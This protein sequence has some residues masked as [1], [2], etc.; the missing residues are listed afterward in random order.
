[1]LCKLCNGTRLIPFV[2][3]GKLIANAW[4]DCDCK[5]PERDH[6]RAVTA[7]GFDFPMSDT[8]RGYSFEYCGQRDPAQQSPK[9]REVVKEVTPQRVIVK[10]HYINADSPRERPKKPVGYKGIK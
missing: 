1:M 8:F 4:L 7:S 9:I 2:K 6:Y 3:N 5:E 10:H